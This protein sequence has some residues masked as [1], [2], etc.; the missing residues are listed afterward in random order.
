MGRAIW[1]LAVVG[2]GAAG[3]AAAR[4]A[5]ELGLTTIV[6]EAKDR[7]GG[8]AWTDMKSLGV[9]WERGANWLHNAETNFFTR[10]ADAHGFA[11]E[12][13]AAPA[14]RLWADGWAGSDLMGARDD[15][16]AQAFRAVQA[17][18]ATGRDIAAAAVI[19]PHPRYRATFAPRFAALAGAEPERTSTLDY[20]RAD[21]SGSNRRLERGFGTLVAHYGRDL[22]V[23]LTTRVTTIRW[24]GSDVHVDT[25]HGG[26]RAHAVIVTVST[27]VL[28]AGRIRFDPALPSAR[29]DALAGVPTGAANKV[30]LAFARNVFDRAAPFFLRFA[31]ERFAPFVFEMRPFGRDLAIGHLGGRWARELEAA[32]AKAMIELATEALAH[33]FGADVRRQLRAAASTAWCSDPEVM[34]GYSCALPGRAHLRPLL[35]EPLAERVFFAGEA[36]SLDHYGTVHGAW[37]TGVAAAHDVARQLRPGAGAPS[38]IAAQPPRPC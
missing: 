26:L 28:A 9:P 1:D 5:L 7:I 32:G 19:P 22:P 27:S 25:P 2:A 8:R 33:A 11:Y 15:Y 4:T 12:S 21:A 18:G 10:Y 14:R 30:A 31:D 20:A 37:A 16:E 35:T 34:G 17:A 38:R 3:L 36:G 24:G 6:L 13:M 29:L 23:R